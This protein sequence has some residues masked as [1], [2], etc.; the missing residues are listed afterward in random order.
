[1][2]EPK[3]ICFGSIMHALYPAV[4]SMAEAGTPLRGPSRD[5]FVLIR[6]LGLR[7]FFGC[8]NQPDLSMLE[9]LT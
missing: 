1:M 7:R 5:M 2:I 9:T 8:S 6:A 3:L 4:K